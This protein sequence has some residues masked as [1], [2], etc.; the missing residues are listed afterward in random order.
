MEEA[1]KKD[2]DGWFHFDTSHMIYNPTVLGYYKLY[3]H[4]EKD[5]IISI[6]KKEEE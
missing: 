4:T 3:V 6:E 2:A 1:I 5:E